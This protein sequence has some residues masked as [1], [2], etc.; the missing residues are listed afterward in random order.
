VGC[1]LVF[2]LA[3]LG[4]QMKHPIFVLRM[5]IEVQMMMREG[6]VSG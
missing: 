4:M 1:L 2:V 6:D 3:M 5:L